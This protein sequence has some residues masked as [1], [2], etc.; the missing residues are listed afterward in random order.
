MK[1]VSFFSFRP[2]PEDAVQP[3]CDLALLEEKHGRNDLHR[4]SVS[5]GFLIVL[6]DEKTK[7]LAFRTLLEDGE[8][9]DTKGTPGGIEKG[10]HPLIRLQVSLSPCSLSTRTHLLV[11]FIADPPWLFSPQAL[12]RQLFVAGSRPGNGQPHFDSIVTYFVTLRVNSV[13]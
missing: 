5:H 12:P 3:F 8:E 10:D 1:S 4:V 11:V 6:H 9:I 7:P 2:T 13:K